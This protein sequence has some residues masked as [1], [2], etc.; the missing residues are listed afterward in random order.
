MNVGFTG[1]QYTSS[2]PRSSPLSIRSHPRPLARTSR[3]VSGQGT[4]AVPT[5]RTVA[6]RLGRYRGRRFRD[7]W[8][9]WRRGYWR[10]CGR[11]CCHC[12]CSC[13]VDRQRCAGR[14]RNRCNRSVGG[15]EGACFS[16][17]K[18]CSVGESSEDPLQI[19]CPSGVLSDAGCC[20]VGSSAAITLA[21]IV[22]IQVAFSECTVG[23]W[24]ATLVLGI[25]RVL[26]FLVFNRNSSMLATSMSIVAHC[27]IAVAKFSPLFF[28]CSSGQACFL[29]LLGL[30]LVV[31]E[32]LS[33]ASRSDESHT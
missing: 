21:R 17:Q 1:Y 7:R 29:T 28:F 8:L 16:L 13:G 33:Q 6:G 25:P 3:Q 22:D 24:R 26:P 31:E 15:Q 23:C 11:Q 10:R 27:V 30:R 12:Y 19:Q 14:G 4:L 18:G 5:Y 20:V 32:V 2:E 9:S